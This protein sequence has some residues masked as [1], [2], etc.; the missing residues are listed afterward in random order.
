V[1]AETFLTVAQAARAAGVSPSLVYQWCRDR[2]LPHYRLGGEGKR[3]R[4]RIAPADLAD[5]IT[6]CRQDRHPLLAS[7]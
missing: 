2:R 3:G 4:I 6:E 1:A 7:E 5:L